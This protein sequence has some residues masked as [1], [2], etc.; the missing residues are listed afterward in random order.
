MKLS[1]GLWTK[2]GII[3][4]SLI[5]ANI[6]VTLF[7][8]ENLFWIKSSKKVSLTNLLFIEGAFIFG[9]GALITSGYTAARID[10]WETMYGSPEGHADYIRQQRRKQIN[11]GIVLMIIGALL[12]I[13]SLAVYYL[14]IDF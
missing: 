2:I 8:G 9:M 10:R 14:L 5:I 1:F 7:V 12:V 13:L 4:L 11:F 6:I 3:I